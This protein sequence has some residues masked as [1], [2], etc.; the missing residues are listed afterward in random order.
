MSFRTIMIVC[1]WAVL[2][3]PAYAGPFN[4][5]DKSSATIFAYNRIGEDAYAASNLRLEEFEAHILELAEGHYHVAALSDVINALKSDSPLPENTVVLTFDGGYRSVLHNAI[6]LMEK[7]GFPYTLFIASNLTKDGNDQYLG[8]NDLKKILRSDLAAI[9]MHPATYANLTGEDETTIRKYINAALG[10]F[11]RELAIRPAFFAYPF[12]EYDTAYAAILSD[13]NFT[14]L[15]GQNSGVA[16]NGSAHDALPRF[17][18]TDAYGDLERFRMAAQ[19]LPL[20]VTHIE[21]QSP[22]VTENPPA[23]GFNLHDDFVKDADSITCFA[24]NQTKPAMQKLGNN[25]IELRLPEPFIDDRARMN[26]T[27]AAGKNENGETIWRW[28]GLLFAY[29]ETPMTD[30]TPPAP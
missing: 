21:P 17:L 5:Y 11:E 22:F 1:L 16:Y 25:R 23:I 13:Y 29:A 24:S 30:D 15:L 7:H 20:P 6:P 4:D 9:G 2:A 14:A 12:G 3:F 19:A 10:D 26:C 8:W 18:M 28:F 27:L